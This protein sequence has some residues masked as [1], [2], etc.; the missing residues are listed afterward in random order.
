MR[1]DVEPVGDDAL[2]VRTDEPRDVT[3]ARAALLRADAAFLEV[4]PTAGR[5]TVVFDPAAL[6]RPVAAGRLS[7]AAR[8]PVEAEAPNVPALVLPVR[9]DGEDL[10]RVAEAAGLSA[11]SVVEAHAGA[12]YVVD[13]LGFTPGFAYLG[14]LPDALAGVARLPSPRLRV[15]GGSV[16]V[17]GGR[18]GVYALAGP[19]GWPLIGRTQA[20]LF[21]P[22]A[23]T[24]FVLTPGRAVRFEPVR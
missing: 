17:A 10:D 11:A 12:A 24:P 5:L 15:P 9:Y 20:R 13:M 19:G 7:R 1:P 16:G 6:P 3:E 8:A 22:D 18:T 14:G 4:V 2:S 23:P 21:T